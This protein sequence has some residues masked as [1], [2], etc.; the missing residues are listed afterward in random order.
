MA[1]ATPYGH[2]DEAARHANINSGTD[3]N[4]F[5]PRVK[6]DDPALRDIWNAD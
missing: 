4:N 6:D 3:T 1:N 5:T 2:I